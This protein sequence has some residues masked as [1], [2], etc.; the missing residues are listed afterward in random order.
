MKK[1]WLVMVIALIAL[2]SC[3]NAETLSGTLTGTNYTQMTWTRG[4]SGNSAGIKTLMIDDIQYT[5]GL[6]MLHVEGEGTF[7]TGAPAGATSPFLARLSNGTTIGTGTLGYQRLYNWLGVEQPGYFWAQFDYWNPS[8]L[9]GDYTLQLNITN[10]LYNASRRWTAGVVGG[11]GRVV[12]GVGTPTEG[13]GGTYYLTKAF[14]FTNDYITVKNSSYVPW[15]T[16]NVTKGSS[17]SRVFIIN[18]ETNATITSEYTANYDTFSFVAPAHVIR[19][20][21]LDTTYS[22][23]NTTNLFVNGTIPTPTPTV[24]PTP[25]QTI[26]PENPIP[27]G[28]TRTTFQAQ[29]AQYGGVVEEASIQLKD[30]ENNSWSNGSYYG[31]GSYYGTW[32]IDTLPAHTINA[33]ASATGYTSTSSLGLVARSAPAYT[34][35]LVPTTVPPAG[36]GNVNLM[37]YV[38][39]KGV[40][41]WGASVTVRVPNGT[42]YAGSTGSN[43]IKN[44]VVPNSS[45]IYVTAFK[46]GYV[47]STKSITTS[48]SGTDSLTI[49]LQELTVTAT[50]TSTIPPGGV[51]T[52]VTIDSRTSNEKDQALMDK[53]RNA[54][55]DLIDLAIAATIIGLVFLMVGAIKIGKK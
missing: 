1:I 39:G 41:M 23:H 10:T 34:L 26:G 54:G 31:A 25:T 27:S 44:F 13:V 20:C 18:G 5:T 32:W 35:N 52:A 8:G 11:G 16:G 47:A 12:F 15:I 29:D 46:T 14:D 9:T 3:V 53:I 28:Y 6:S 42:T 4:V 36:D 50:A 17:A 21:A 30:V 40:S 43:G 2:V 37:V 45:L 7:D 38:M 24:T 55:P 19:I 33:Y 48:A 51:T 22:W 49:D